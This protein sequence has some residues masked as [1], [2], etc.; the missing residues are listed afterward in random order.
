MNKKVLI[1]EDEGI[2]S[3]ELENKIRKWGYDPV[4][5]A[6][7]G[8][9][10]MV[11]A[12]DLKPDLI[13][14]DIRLQGEEDGVE[15]AE[16]ILKEMKISLIYITAHSSDFMMDRAHKTSPHAY[17]IKPFND[18]ELKFAVEMALYK[19]EMEGKLKESENKYKTLIDNLMVGVFITELNG[20]ILMMNQYLANLSNGN[21]SEG[22]IGRNLRSM[23]D[24]SQEIEKLMGKLENEGN[25]INEN[26]T[27][28]NGN[29]QKIEIEFSAKISKNIVYGVVTSV[30][31]V[32]PS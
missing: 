31:E 10:A 11:M 1:V 20:N 13:L 24:Q 15:V 14:M 27:L 4:G 3:L 29:N 30:K 16:K 32:Y 17:F 28:I 5:V 6:V 18:N 9:E 26:L 8:E 21:S 2:T 23:F 19:H 22:I 12:R 25:L 7:S